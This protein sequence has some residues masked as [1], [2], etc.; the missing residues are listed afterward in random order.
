MQFRERPVPGFH[1]L[2][3]GSVQIDGF[4]ED[5][6]HVDLGNV[7][8]EVLYT[9]GHSKCS[10]SLFCRE[11]GVLFVG[12]VIPQRNGL[13]IYDDVTTT[14]ESIKKLK[15]IDGIQ[16]GLSS[17][18]DPGKREDAY[19]MMDEGL[20]YLQR[21]HNGI[22]KLSHENF[23]HDPMKLCAEMVRDLGLP[24]VAINPLIAGSFSSH[25]DILDR[26]D[27]VNG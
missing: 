6:D 24:E 26:K 19:H 18:N 5:G 7:S 8:L 3:G 9:P 25:L 16:Y 1:S 2:V 22:R 11:D 13:P 17:W 23:L 21:I 14:V 15:R 20:E 4:L 12:D 27:L 10:I